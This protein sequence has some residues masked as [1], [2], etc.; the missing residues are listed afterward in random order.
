M[1]NY[2]ISVFGLWHLGCIS[3]A[4]LAEMGYTVIGTEFDRK[5]ID[6]LNKCNP[7]IFEPELKELIS[8]NL[9]KNLS[10]TYDKKRALAESDFIFIAF[11]TKVNDED[12]VDISTV[13]QSVEVIGNECKEDAIII[14]TSQ[15][16]IGTCDI[17]RER[18]YSIKGQNKTDVV[19][20]PENLRLGKAIE[21]FMHPDRIVIGA[22]NTGT[23]K[24]IKDLFSPIQCDKLGM[25][26]RSAEM[27]KHALNSY[28]ATCISFISEISDYCEAGN[29][30]AFD[31]VKALKTD[32]RV[33]PYAPISPG[34]GF[35]GGTLARDVQTLR[36]FARKNNID[37]KLMDAVLEVNKERKNVLIKKII[38]SL[39]DLNGVN[40]GIL[41]L[42]YKAGTDTLRRSISLEVATE[43]SSM[44]A[45][46][47][48]YDPKINVKITEHPE[49][50]ICDSP[51]KVAE[52]AKALILLT[53]W[54]EFRHFDYKKIKDLMISPNFFDSKNFLEPH[55]MHEL[56]YSYFGM[57]INK[58]EIEGK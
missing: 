41:G 29:A 58:T 26:V 31:V 10:F 39:G 22:D 55:A 1:T 32:R 28:L 21:I 47:K 34:F 3:A 4:C 48:A 30:N 12:M 43:L 27:T 15:V 35:A 46:I 8:K 17:I 14:V 24:K 16:P 53:E 9:N 45:K 37:S 54:P 56:G 2:K 36:T 13:M 5:V 11:D 6:N 23:M 19:Y 49:I 25:S 42:T 33:S 50:L 20:M 57:G 7:P 51:E 40:I 44:G 18:I 38:R 52:D